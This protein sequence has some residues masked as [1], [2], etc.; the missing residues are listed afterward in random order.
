MDAEGKFQI[1]R[2]LVS[3]VARALTRGMRALVLFLL[4]TTLS[5]QTVNFGFRVGVPL[6]KPSANFRESPAFLIDPFVEF[7][8]YRGFAVEGSAVHQRVGENAAYFFENAPDT[9]T[10]F[11]GHYSATTWEFPFVGKYYFRPRQARWRPYA[12]A[13]W[14]IRTIGYRAEGIT[15]FTSPASQTQQAL[16]TE[17][18]SGPGSGATAVA[19]VGIGAGPFRF[20]PEVRY[21]YWG[22]REPDLR[23]NQ[24]GVFLGFS[25]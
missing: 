25:F 6:V 15:T 22:G 2:R 17:R 1:L 21:T 13:G 18:R 24:A 8:I 20:S 10:T 4:A 19:G 7:H 12:G 5:A 16:D 23:K 11:A 9:R 14:S 3:G